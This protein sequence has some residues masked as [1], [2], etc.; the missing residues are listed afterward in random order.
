MSLGEM[1][2]LGLVISAF[3]LFA[4]VAAYVSTPRY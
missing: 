1:L 2:F 3:T 4:V